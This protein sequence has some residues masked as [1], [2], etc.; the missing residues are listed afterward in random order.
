MS[1][2]TRGFGILED[3]VMLCQDIY[4]DSTTKYRSVRG[5][6]CVRVKQGCLL[7]PVQFNTTLQGLLMEGCAGRYCFM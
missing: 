5:P 4:S 2:M 1:S 6:Q 3:F 7:S